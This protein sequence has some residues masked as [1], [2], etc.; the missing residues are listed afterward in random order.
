MLQ[1]SIRGIYSVSKS[2]PL[3]KALAELDHVG[4][5]GLPKDKQ[6]QVEL[7]HAEAKLAQA[8]IKN[9]FPLLHAHT[10]VAIWGAL[11]ST[12]PKLVVRWLVNQPEALKT[13]VFEKLRVPVAIYERLDQEERAAYLVNQI[14]QEHRITTKPG[15]GRFEA[16]LETI[17]L[18]GPVDDKV[19]RDLFEMS[20][21]RNLIVHHFSIV[22]DRF[23]DSCPWLDVEVGTRFNVG[24]DDYRRYLDATHAYTLMVID[25]IGDKLGIDTR[26]SRQD[27]GPGGARRKRSDAPEEVARKR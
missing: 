26:R 1:L 13:P 14:I 7:A 8:E 23:K 17:E 21:V 9:D 15:V 20:Q 25:R 4:E 18:S 24:H 2:A 12:I 22:D 27:D 5:E 19:R 6:Q 11:E 10:I 3:V 16:L